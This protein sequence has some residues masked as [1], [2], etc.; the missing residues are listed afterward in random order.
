MHHLP[1]INVLLSPV[2]DGGVSLNR[3]LDPHGK[4]FSDVLLSATVEL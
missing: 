2:L 4:S 1:A 3:R